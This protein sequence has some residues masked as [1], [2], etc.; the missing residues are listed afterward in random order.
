[1]KKNLILLSLAALVCLGVNTCSA[2]SIKVEVEVGKLH[3]VKVWAQKTA[4]Y[5]APLFLGNVLYAA[6][7][8]NSKK[9]RESDGFFGMRLSHTLRPLLIGAFAAYFWPK[10]S[11]IK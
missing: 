11:E 5:A 9:V 8:N 7:E 1:M 6:L 3:N 4:L 10:A 2:G